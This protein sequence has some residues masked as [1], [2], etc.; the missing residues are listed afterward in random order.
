MSSMGEGG[1]SMEDA[2]VVREGK[3]GPKAVQISTFHILAAAK[4]NLEDDVT[5][6]GTRMSIL[7]SSTPT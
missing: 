4:K 2:V 7:S 5:N 6:F 3:K 1:L